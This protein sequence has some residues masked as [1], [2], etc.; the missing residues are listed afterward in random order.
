VQAVSDIK[1]QSGG[2]GPIALIWLGLG[3]NM[4]DRLRY[5]RR[6]LLALADE[7]ELRVVRVS[8]VYETEY[9]GEGQQ[10]PYLNACVAIESVLEPNQLL[11][12]LKAIEVRE[13]RPPQGH[14][15]PR[16]IDLDIL[17]WGDR[18]LIT[19]DLQIPHKGMRDRAFVLIPLAAIAAEMTFPDSGE[20]IAEACANIRRKSGP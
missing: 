20:T 4:G 14:M 19:T 17:L 12:I 6:A 1:G 8:P 3:T 2:E 15:L 18:I 11:A 13:G 5:L 9:V 16:P 10:A 7:P